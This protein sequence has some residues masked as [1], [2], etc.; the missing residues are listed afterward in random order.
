MPDPSMPAVTLPRQILRAVAAATAI[1]G[2][3]TVTGAPSA[4]A[5]RGLLATSAT[6]RL[7]G[8]DSASFVAD[9]LP[10]TEAKYG[11][12][13]FFGRYISTNPQCN[14]NGLSAADVQHLFSVGI[15]LALLDYT[16]GCQAFNFHVTSQSDGVNAAKRA[17]ASAQAMHVPAGIAL[18]EDIEFDAPVTTA[19]L[20]GYA[21]WMAGHS[22]YVPGFYASVSKNTTQNQSAFNDAMCGGLADPNV[23]HA[24]F[25][26]SNPLSTLGRTSAK[27]MPPFAPEQVSCRAP[28]PNPP[29]KAM[30]W[31][32]GRD[33]AT[34]P[35]QPPNIDTDEWIGTTGL[36]IPP[37]PNGYWL[38]SADGTVSAAGQAAQ[39][40]SGT[41]PTGEQ[42][43]GVASSPDGFGYWVATRDGRVQGFGDALFFGDLPGEHVTTNDI[44]AIAPTADG[45]GYWLIGAD[46]GEFAFG[47]AGYHGSLPG[48]GVHVH[49]IV[50]MVAAAHGYILVGSD[51]GVFVFGGSFHG[52]LPGVH[53]HVNDIVGILPTG[54]GAGYVLVGSDGG[55]FVFG[56]GSGYYGSLPGKGIHVKDVVGLAL[57]TDQHG[58]WMATSGGQTFPFG[59]ATPFPP[60]TGVSAHLPVTGIAGT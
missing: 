44:V 5:S 47:D 20:E 32:Y 59:D 56:G 41:L 2:L 31:Q 16:D 51:G 60:P 27:R 25:W 29:P 7:W 52:S 9:V 38:V 28:T 23:E 24:L 8:V 50:G 55:A 10:A 14:G 19:F 4:T 30:A 53:V 45:G 6:P 15:A 33:N 42:A 40:G 34:G 35:P 49:D 58:Y 57:T 39:L 37:R 1:F 12:P 21:D 54:R 36:W 46:G 22:R 26:A 48:I 13:H 18:F 11:R 43:V 17:I 3:A